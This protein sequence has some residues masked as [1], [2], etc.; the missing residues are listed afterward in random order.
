MATP[1]PDAV[2][3]PDTAAAA[4]AA[5]T[6]PTADLADVP[7]PPPGTV[8]APL[9]PPSPYLQAPAPTSPTASRAGLGILAALAAALVGAAV[10]GG[11]IR[12]TEREI[13][14]AALAV[15]A[16]VG[17]ALGKVGGRSQTLPILGVPIALLGVFLGQ[18]F[19]LALLVEHELGVS[20]STIVLDHPG[21]LYDTWKDE[22]SLMDLLFFGI[23]GLEGYIFAR[24]L[25]ERG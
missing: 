7:G 13:G 18:L 9:P 6:T 2:G 14:Y 8:G 12:F 15:G 16:L 1:T 22:L 19:G 4:P 17:A 10:Y 24:R 11:I 23:A 25:G 3:E 21:A 20:L 5:P